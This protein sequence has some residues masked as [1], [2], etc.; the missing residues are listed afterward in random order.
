MPTK[1]IVG[2]GNPGPKYENT[3]HNLGILGYQ[4][5]LVEITGRPVRTRV[6][7]TYR[8]NRMARLGD[9]LCQTNDVHEQ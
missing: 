2:L 9:Y 8:S 7:V 5:T 4:R 1:L 6:S 3:K